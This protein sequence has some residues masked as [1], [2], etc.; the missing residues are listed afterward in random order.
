MVV[1]KPGAAQ[2]ELRV[3]CPAIP[4]DAFGD[5][6]KL[7]VMNYILG[8][9]FNSRINLNLRETHGFTYGARSGFNSL[10]KYGHFVISTGV[11][12][13]KTDS[14]ISEIISELKNWVMTGMTEEELTYAKN[15][16]SRSNMLDN[17]TG[18]QVLQQ[19]REV[20]DRHLQGD[21]SMRQMGILMSLQPKDLNR[22][23]G[24]HFNPDKMVIVVVGDLDVVLKD[25]Q[26]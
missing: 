23:A 13:D 26:K 20:A 15:A 25:L 4:Y 12:K 2:S 22:L 16:I 7:G 1:H 11:K 18:T 24:F 14:S 9:S 21:F 17:E 5:Y 10:E 8:E 6:F 3:A 19:L